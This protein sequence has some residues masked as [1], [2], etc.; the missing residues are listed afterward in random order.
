MG[1]LVVSSLVTNPMFGIMLSIMSYL[2]GLLV[3]RRFPSSDDTFIGRYDSDY[4]LFEADA[5]FL[6]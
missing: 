6:P 5:Y 2:V 3:F 1:G 4:H